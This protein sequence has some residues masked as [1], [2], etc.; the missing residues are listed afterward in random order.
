MTCL[1]MLKTEARDQAVWSAT[2]FLFTPGVIAASA[3]W[4]S[5]RAEAVASHAAY[6]SARAWGMAM[7]HAMKP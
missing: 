3:V 6:G 5:A 7:T 2:A 4:M 1:L